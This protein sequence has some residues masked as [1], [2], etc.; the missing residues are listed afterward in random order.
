MVR[1]TVSKVSPDAFI[2]EGTRRAYYRAEVLL[3][4]GEA[5]KLGGRLVAGMP[6]EVFI[7]TGARTPVDYLLKPVTDY[8]G[9]ALREG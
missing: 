2:E 5:A 1:G 7:R 3:A 9:R 8:F 6:V 4:D